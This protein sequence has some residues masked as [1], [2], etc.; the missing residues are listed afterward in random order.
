[1][2]CG[3]SGKYSIILHMREL[4]KE[5]AYIRSFYAIVEECIP[6][7]KKYGIVL[8]QT[9]FYPEGGGQPS[10]TGI[11]ADVEV[12]DVQRI[13]EKIVH[14]TKQPL[15][16]GKSVA[17]SIDWSRRFSHMQEHT[18]EHI[19][20]GLVHQMYGY[21]NVGFH[22]GAVITVDFNGP[23]SW[24]QLAA[25][26]KRANQVVYENTPVKIWYPNEIQERSIS[27]RSKKEIDEDLRIVEIPDVDRCACCG[28]HVKRT[29]E[30]G[31][32]KILS[33]MNYKQ[34]VRM[35]MICGQKAMEDYVYKHD[36]NKEISIALKAKTDRTGQAVQSLLE[37]YDQ[38]E[39]ELSVLYHQY[40]ALKAG[41]IPKDA[42]LAV[43]FEKD[44]DSFRVKQFCDFLIKEKK[45]KVCVVISAHYYVM[46]S[47]TMDLRKVKDLLHER[48]QGRGG[49]NASI[50]QGQF[51]AQEETIR[52]CLQDVFGSNV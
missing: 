19:V 14:F 5:D 40:Y 23:L 42:P 12:I 15:E 22:M 48:L 7:K 32:I 6:L 47:E 45:A 1:M 35:E 11:I 37:R 3:I 8:D 51:L 46:Q 44:W 20:S 24:Q 52:Q 41:Q 43:F 27:Y 21:D 31:P 13:D 28:T 34:G 33:V 9:A 25:I 36:Q 16:P 30:I 50:L 2:H 29:G 26:E 39:K 38:K 49:G 17:A 18:G 10:D 4:F